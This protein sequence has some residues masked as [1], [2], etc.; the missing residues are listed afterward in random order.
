MASRKSKAT[1]ACDVVALGNVH[2][3]AADDTRVTIA[4]NRPPQVAILAQIEAIIAHAKENHDVR[5]AVRCA[6]RTGVA[7]LE[8]ARV[9]AAETFLARRGG[10]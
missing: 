1:H 4:P 9:I 10:L 2:R 6:L 8:E 3:L 5:Q 7:E